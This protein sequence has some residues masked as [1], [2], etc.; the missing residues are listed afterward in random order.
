MPFK[1]KKALTKKGFDVYTAPEVPTV[2]MNGGCQYPGMPA[3]C[4]TGMDG[5]CQIG[6]LS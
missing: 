2:M 1:K 6:V 4:P 5:S 3:C